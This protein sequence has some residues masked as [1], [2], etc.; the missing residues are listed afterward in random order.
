MKSVRMDRDNLERT[1]TEQVENAGSTP[2]STMEAYPA[3]NQCR[4]LSLCILRRGTFHS[5]PAV[6]CQEHLFLL[7]APGIAA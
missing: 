5:N 2:P 6:R 7:G 1:T 4:A 3:K